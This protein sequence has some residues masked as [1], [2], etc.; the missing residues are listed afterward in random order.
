MIA[1]NIII[2]V[3]IMIVVNIFIVVNIIIVVDIMIV[4]N[5]FIVVDF[6]IVVNIITINLDHHLSE[7]QMEER[8]KLCKS[9]SW[10]MRDLWGK[11][12][13]CRI[14]KKCSTLGKFL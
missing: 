2:V 5:I 7:R 13:M 12:Q 11:N 1:V 9:I 6:F 14:L 8:T 4:V 10:T 3:K